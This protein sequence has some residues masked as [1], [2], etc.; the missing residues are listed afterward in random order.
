[1]TAVTTTAGAAS[2][3]E[4][5]WHAIDWPKVHQNV[6]RL[7]ARIVK[8]TQEGRWGRVKALQRL[9][10]HSFSAKALAVK[11][12]TENHGKRTPGVDGEIWSTPQQKTQA[13][14]RLRQRGY[15]PQPLRRVYIPKSNGKKRPLS[16]CT[17][18]DRAMQAVYLLALDPIAETKADHNSYGFRKGRS[19]A[20]AIEQCFVILA[21][22]NSPRWIL[23]AD[24]LACYERISHDWLLAHIPMDK[25]LLRQWLKAGYLDQHVLYPIEEGVPQGSI[26]GPVLAN[27]TLDG[28]EARLREHFPQRIQS[29]TPKVHLIRYADDV[30]LTGDSQELLAQ[31]V[32]PVV[33]AFLRE[34]GLEL[35]S[36]KTRIV[37]IETG[38]DFLG[39]NVR[40]YRNG[41]QRKLLIK[42]AGK[43]VKSFLDKVRSIVK[44]NK[45]AT[46]GN[47][48]KQLNPVILGWAQSHQHVVSKSTYNEVDHAIF[49]L[50]WQWAQRRHANKPR[51]WI[52]RKYFRTVGERSWVFYGDISGKKSERQEIRLVH[53]TD[54][55]IKR[56]T[57][58][59]GAAN[60]YDPQWETYFEK[61]SDLKMAASLRGRRKLLYLWEQQQGICPVCQQKITKLTGWDN[62][63][64]I[65]RVYGGND[66]AENRVLLH[67]N[68][69]RQA[70]SQGLEVVKPR[71][72]TGERKA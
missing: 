62:H 24:I 20:D 28:L 19:T 26:V 71:P 53:A 18:Q 50:L 69:H 16:I 23:D 39:Q 27:L 42:P 63:H 37:H 12:V 41:C 4:M 17:M 45:Q 34:R 59:Q 51:E 60:P 33:E 64:I 6:R 70:H 9:L 36:E 49:E 54:V 43:N 67:P 3:A 46:A 56:H 38:F 44:D 61:R 10:T 25:S 58:I 55:P 1:M 2:H 52:K 68:C 15:Q 21:R 57:K 48:L 13:I 5:E 72:A 22:K 31:Q 32:K 66:G 40:K 7:Q 8:A 11:R 29:G 14:R 35:S 65:W 30:V 47:L